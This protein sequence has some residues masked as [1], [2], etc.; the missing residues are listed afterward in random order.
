MSNDKHIK[1]TFLYIIIPLI[2]N[3]ISFLILP[4]LTHY[5]NTSDYGQ[6]GLLGMFGSVS[7]PIVTISI[8]AATYRYYFKY[9]KNNDSLKDMFSTHFIAQVL[10]SSVFC[11]LISIYIKEVNFYLFKSQLNE[12]WVIPIFIKTFVMNINILNQGVYQNRL[13]GKVWFRNELISL[14]VQVPL[15]LLLVVGGFATFEALILPI[16]IAEIVKAIILFYGLREYYSLIVKWKF[17]KEGITYSW[18]LMINSLIAIGFTAVDKI[19]LVRYKPIDE[20]GILDMSI[21]IAMVLKLMIDAV[22]RTFTP[23]I[24]KSLEDGSTSAK[25]YL[26]K[27]YYKVLVIIFF[28]GLCIILFSDFLVVV[29]MSKEFLSVKYVAPIYIYYNIFGAIGLIS[30]WLIHQSGKTYFTIPV[31]VSSLIINVFGNILLVPHLGAVGAALTTLITAGF[32][33]IINLYLGMKV[34][35]IPLKVSKI[36]ILILSMFCN[37]LAVYILYYF[38]ISVFY[39]VFIKIILLIMFILFTLYIK[40]TSKEDFLYLKKIIVSIV[41]KISFNKKNKLN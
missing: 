17:I 34:N 4:I 19:V 14:V 18:P 22:G 16:L 29:L 36:L 41:T 3:G 35:P 30:Y 32:Q 39:Q 15:Q 25:E 37:T 31:N 40:V 27:V 10:L 28:F 24:M 1:N 8:G 6:A 9:E 7:F 21:K 12:K 33:A 2:R 38:N 13:N 20:I 5:L 26:C 23:I 11:I